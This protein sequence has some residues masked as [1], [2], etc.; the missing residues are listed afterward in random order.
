MWHSAASISRIEDVIPGLSPIAG[1]RQRC[2]LTLAVSMRILVAP[3]CSPLNIP[4]NLARLLGGNDDVVAFALAPEDML[5][6]KRSFVEMARST[7]LFI[8]IFETWPFFAEA[9]RRWPSRFYR[10]GKCDVR[11]SNR[12]RASIQKDSTKSAFSIKLRLVMVPTRRRCLGQ[13]F[14]LVVSAGLAQMPVSASTNLVWQP[15][16]GCRFAPLAVPQMGQAG[17]TLLNPEQT[18][19]SFSN[20]LSEAAVST[21]RL[22][23]IGSGVALGDIDG[24]G[25]VD[26]YFCRLEGGNVLYRN[27]GNWRFADITASAGVECPNQFSTG[28]VFADVDGDGHLDL[29]VNSLGGGTR[30]FLN[31]GKGHFTEKTESGLLRHFGATSMALADVKG[32]G[33]LDLYVANYRTDTFFD[34]PPGLRV[35]MRPQSDGTVAAEPRDRFVTL[36]VPNRTPMVL[37]RGEPHVLYINRGGGQFAPIP[38]QVGVFLGEDGRPVREPPTDWGLSV[39]FRDLD[40]DG[41]PDLYVCNDFVYWPDR[42]WLNQNGQRFRAAARTVLRC[43]SLSS[44]AI[45]VADINRDGFDDLFVADMLSPRRAARAWQRPD[46]LKGSIKWPTEDP[47]FR[48]EVPRNTLQLARGDGTYAEIALLAGVAATDWTTSAA[49]L[50]VDLDGWEDLLLSTGNNRDVQDVDA[51][52]PINRGGGWK[53]PQMRLM[54]WRKLPRREAANVALRNSHNLTFEDKSAAWGFNAVGIAHGMAFADLDND[55]DLDVVVNS[56]NAPARIYR[57]NSP[58]PRIAVRLKGAGANTRGIGAK[59][60]VI[61]GPVTQTQEM[62][63]GGRYCSSDDPMRVFAAGDARQLRIEVAWRSGK[64]SLV[65]NALPNCVYEIDESYAEPAASAR[66]RDSLSVSTEP[67]VVKDFKSQISDPKFRPGQPLFEDISAHLNHVHVD[68]PFDDF[69]RQ[70]LLPHKL[71]TLGPGVCWAD[72]TG[73]GRDDL[74]IGG[75]KDGRAAIFRNDGKGNLVEWADAPVPKCNPRDQTTLLVWRGADGAARLIAGEA[76]WEDADT[77]APPFR[78]AELR[79]G[80]RTS[81][82]QGLHSGTSA[83]GPLALADVDGD[84]NLDLFVGGRVAAGRYPEPVNSYLLRPEGGVFCI[85]QTFPG[86]GLVSGAVFIDFDSDGWPDLALA[87]EWDS[88]R[89][90]HNDHGK[91][92]EVTSAFGLA[93]FKGWWN[94]IAVGDFDGDGRLDL[95]ASNWGRNWRLDQPAG[96]NMPVCLYYGDFANN[97]IVQTLLASADPWLSK[98]TPWRER[99]TVCGALPSVVER[100][101]NHHAYGLASVQEMLGD[102]MATAHELQAGTFDSM[103]FL[104]RGDHFEA[105]PLPLEAQFAPG[106][107]VTVSDF[108][109]DGNEDVFLAQNFFG[110]DAETS[111]HDAGI[112]LVLLGDGHG[113]FRALGPRASGIAIFGEQRGSAVADFDGD[114]RPDL[115][116]AQHCGQTKLYRNLGG[117]AGVRVI[118]KGPAGNPQAVGAVTRLKFAD[119][120]GP[121]RESHAGGGYWSQDSAT[122]IMAA[123]SLPQALQVRWPGGNL[124]TWSWP[125]TAKSVEVTTNGIAVRSDR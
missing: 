84:G 74:L 125:S 75:G 31:D 123:P 85:A 42:L 3:A 114:G 22:L 2:L 6:E 11:P 47:D 41:L 82:K 54:D 71:S 94:G 39:I 36:P 45:D 122:F 118:L 80:S 64:R 16:P 33:T 60:K 97:G 92:T 29:L 83:T 93:Q 112:G 110:V 124:Q 61:G 43:T 103:V 89:L 91:F 18:G 56:L 9:T 52:A 23:E 86:L 66:A 17:F 4:R 78:V 113:D 20:R 108:D 14:A 58:A 111:R 44:M 88:I 87:C 38:W 106:F 62:I 68:S 8:F 115:A 96:S 51:I 28:C 13:T 109:G 49:F 95:V 76:N 90:F 37:E 55:G 15:G 81:I 73:D 57:N 100:L 99:K 25:W 10:R 21:N 53:T 117:A 101:P 120:W 70:P 59:I 19:I 119:H 72:L 35:E 67:P 5:P 46:T 27:L 12:F 105:H 121:A 32:N 104:N 24:D 30:L 107:G 102:Q 98:V 79:A 77:N 48:P 69:A 26:I 65:T 1:G 34:N 116:V 40:G 50:D 63:A 7:R